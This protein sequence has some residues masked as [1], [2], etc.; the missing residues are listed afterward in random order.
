VI[1]SARNIEE[2]NRVRNNLG[3]AKNKAIIIPL[4][5]SD[6]DTVMKKGKEIMDQYN[7]DILINNAGISQRSSFLDS[8]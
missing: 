5:I 4:D 2:L 3:V 1:L 7:V 8:I 6:T